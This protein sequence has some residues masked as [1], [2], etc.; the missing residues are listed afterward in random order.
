MARLFKGRP[1]AK[2]GWNHS[3][4][5]HKTDQ[6]TTKVEPKPQRSQGRP[7]NLGSSEFSDVFLDIWKHYYEDMD[8]ALMFNV[9]IFSDLEC[10]VLEFPTGNCCMNSDMRSCSV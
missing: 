6:G 7:R 8:N 5:E 2:V 4:S 10:S 9:V 3:P 1:K